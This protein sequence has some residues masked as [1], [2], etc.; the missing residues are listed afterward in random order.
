M[1]H[2]QFFDDMEGS[3]N[4]FYRWWEAIR[5]L[6][7][8]SRLRGF[9]LDTLPL[10]LSS[11]TRIYPYPG[12]FPVRLDMLAHYDSSCGRKVSS[13]R[14]DAHS[15]GRYLPRTEVLAAAAMNG[16]LF[17]RFNGDSFTS[18]EDG[19]LPSLDITGIM[20]VPPGTALGG[21]YTYTYGAA[22]CLA[23][24]ATHGAPE[25]SVKFGEDTSYF[26]AAP[27]LTD[28]SAPL[29][30]TPLFVTLGSGSS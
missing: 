18:L 10:E 29:N 19:L 27:V 6:Y 20:T 21:R 17:P 14:Q 25:L 15:T 5:Y 3:R 13:V 22:L 1:L 9:S 24:N 28:V 30:R 11:A 26:S 7:P 4:G 8:G 16:H 2:V 12:I 23:W